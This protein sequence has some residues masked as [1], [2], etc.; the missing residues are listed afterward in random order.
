MKYNQAVL[1]RVYK[2]RKRRNIKVINSNSTVYK[3]FKG[4]YIISFIAFIIIPTFFIAV[5][6]IIYH[7]DWSSFSW[8]SRILLVL[9]ISTS[10]YGFI[11]ILKNKILLGGT[12]NFLSCL[13]I[14]V[15]VH[16]ATNSVPK[17]IDDTVYEFFNIRF[18]SEFVVRHLIPFVLIMITGG[19][20]CIIV[21]RAHKL[22]KRDYEKVLEA[23]YV[24]N[25]DKLSGG[26]EDAWE[27]LLET[28]DDTTIEK[29]VSEL[30]N[31][32]Y[33]KKQEEKKAKNI[34]NNE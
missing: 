24:A 21:Y 18:T 26:G 3:V 25:H 15:F 1:D 9:L 22:L 27:E 33:L 10:I 7:K 4:L 30:E 31:A 17:G 20:M 8:F 5:P 6:S 32:E 12:T 13:G 29:Q 14:T 2:F 16:I 19:V 28:L 11:C 34:K 23:V